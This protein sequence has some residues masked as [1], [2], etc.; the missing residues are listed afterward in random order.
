MEIPHQ[1]LELSIVMPDITYQAQAVLSVQLELIMPVEL[2]QAAQRVAVGHILPPALI[3]A[4]H[5]QF[6]LEP[7]L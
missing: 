3:H 2:P 4:H 5:A 6:P 7:P 1:G